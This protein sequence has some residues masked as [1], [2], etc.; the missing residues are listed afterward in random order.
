MASKYSLDIEAR[1]FFSLLSKVIFTNPFSVT[2]SD[3]EQLTGSAVAFP[4]EDEDEHVFSALAPLVDERLAK[5]AQKGVETLDHVASEH[6]LV[7]R[8]AFLFQTYHRYIAEFD[9]L[10]KAQVS[11]PGHSPTVRFADPLMRELIVRGFS[12]DEAAHYFGL[13]YQLRRAYYFI[14]RSLAGHSPSMQALRKSLWNNVFIHDTRIYEA[15]LW[16]RMEDFS[17]LLLGETGTGKGSAAAAIGR[18]SYIPLDTGKRQF[19]HSFTDIFIA[20]NLSQFPETLIESELFGHKKGA[21]TGAM[22]D[23]AGLFERC[24]QYGALFLDEIGDVGASVQLKLL[25]V[26]QERTFSPVGSHAQRRFSGRVIAAT[27]RSIGELRKQGRFRDDF[28]Y[29]LCSD[30]IVV[31]TLRQRLSESPGE[32]EIL[33]ALLL[34]RMM[35]ADQTQLTDMVMSTLKRD[36]AKDYR[37]P[38]NV[39]ELEQAVRRVLLTQGYSGDLTFAH[40]D[41]EEAFLSD[42]RAGTLSAKSLMSRYCALLYERCGTYEEV[43]RRAG[44]DRRTVKKH[45]ETVIE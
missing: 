23:H 34:S 15:F 2:R 31:P 35:G 40:M 39:R 18:S 24:S 45:L 13:F 12:V 3:V 11:K 30:V 32:L 37:W 22:E 19:T 38:G 26:I 8:H 28:F 7:M 4:L 5:L 9:R 6:Q 44:L 14:V 21:F 10:I 25:Q 41:R 33:V 27:N 1:Q 42:F 20:T 16:P 36:L 43:A 29:R 17:T